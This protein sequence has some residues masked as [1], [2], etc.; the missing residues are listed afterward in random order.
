MRATFSIPRTLQKNCNI[1]NNNNEYFHNI[2]ILSLYRNNR[3][4]L[5]EALNICT[6][7]STILKQKRLHTCQYPI[8]VHY[9]C[10]LHK[11]YRRGSRNF[12][13][14]GGD[15]ERKMFVNTLS[16][17]VYI[18]TRQTCN[19]FSLLSFQED[20]LLF[21]VLFYYSVLFLKFEKGGCKPPP[22]PR[23]A[24]ALYAQYNIRQVC[25]NF[26]MKFLSKIFISSF[27]Y[28][29]LQVQK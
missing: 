22:P 26:S 3:F 6:E 18:K 2:S 13:K 10:S 8:Y 12:S 27:R 16:T 23:S 17:R 4:I 1:K 7:H 24:N 20:C 11:H 19:S 14:G 15:F 21:F 29:C 25:T 9:T 5:L 28:I